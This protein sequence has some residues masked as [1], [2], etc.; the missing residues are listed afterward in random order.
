MLC[1]TGMQRFVH[2]VLSSGSMDCSVLEVEVEGTVEKAFYASKDKKINAH[3]NRHDGRRGEKTQ[4]QTLSSRNCQKF[5]CSPDCHSLFDAFFCLFLV[6]L[7]LIL[8]TLFPCSVCR[9]FAILEDHTLAHNL[10]EQES[11]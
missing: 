9:D 2:K 6:F 10:Q 7:V 3:K 8:F 4:F 1:L 5:I 11:K